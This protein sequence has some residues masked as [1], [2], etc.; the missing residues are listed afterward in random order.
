MESWRCMVL[1]SDWADSVSNRKST[2]GRCFSLDSSMVS[3]FSMKLTSIALNSEEL[4]YM[5]ANSASCEIIWLHKLLAELTY[6]P[7]DATVIYCFF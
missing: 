3:W 6:Q 2:L 1:D 4:E 7:L 5:A